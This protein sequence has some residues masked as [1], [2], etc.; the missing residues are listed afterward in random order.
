[1]MKFRK[2]KISEFPNLLFKHTFDFPTQSVRKS[3]SR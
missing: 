3:N 1:M 2:S